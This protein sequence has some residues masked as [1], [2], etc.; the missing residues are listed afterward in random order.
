MVDKVGIMHITGPAVIKAVTGEDVTSEQIGGARAHNA[1]S[2]WPSSSPPAGECF[3]Q[4]RKVLSYLPQQQHGGSSR[5]PARGR[6]R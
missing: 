4:V 2:G 3:A 5:L 1:T 6:P